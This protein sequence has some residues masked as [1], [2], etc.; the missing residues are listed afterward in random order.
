[1]IRAIWPS[2]LAALAL[3]IPLSSADLPLTMAQ[4]GG[5]RQETSATRRDAA[6]RVRL[7]GRVLRDDRGPFP[8]LGAS[9]FWALW[10]EQHDAARLDANLRWLAERGVDHVRILGMVG[11]ETWADR[12]IDPANPYYWATVDRLLER[13]AR[14]GLRAHVALF[15]DAQV[16]MARVDDRARFAEAWARKA[17]EHP[18]RFVLLEVANEHWQNGLEDVAEVR[19]LGARLSEQTEVLVA[20]SAP[21]ADRACELYAGSTADVA[22]VH[23]GREAPSDDPWGSIWQPW[24]WPSAHDASCRGRLPPAM[25]SEPIGPQSSVASDDNPLRLTMAYVTTF[26]AGNA[27]Y[28]LH[29]GAGVRGGGA[30]DRAMGRSANVWETPRID[31]ALEGMRSA[32]SYLPS[33]VANWSRYDAD[34]QPHPVADFEQAIDAGALRRALTAGSRGRYVT[35]L[36]G[37]RRPAAIRATRACAI[38]VRNPLTGAIMARYKPASGERFNLAGGEA[39]ILTAACGV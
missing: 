4:V 38:E 17:N 12:R 21:L 26:L 24:G 35:A 5:V 28:V 36:L 15:A 20:L 8:A 11:S 23:Y 30:A 31:E 19:A 32:R 14:H 1:V 22:T 18:E 7:D 27:S 3:G 39:V 34:V 29:T 9:L 33:D 25:N 13:L 16:M 6:G 2:A 37:L 10:G